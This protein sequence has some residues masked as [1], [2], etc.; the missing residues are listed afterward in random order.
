MMHILG[1][2]AKTVHL[3]ITLVRHQRVT[4]RQKKGVKDAQKEIEVYWKKYREDEINPRRLL[5][6]LSEL[7]KPSD[8]YK[9]P[10]DPDN[11][12]D[13]HHRSFRQENDQ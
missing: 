1:M 5:L 12:E 9:S 3:N 8:V 2:E 4:R 6:K 7:L 13:P 11:V 10:S